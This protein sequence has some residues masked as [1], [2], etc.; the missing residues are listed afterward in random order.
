MLRVCFI[1]NIANY[2]RKLYDVTHNSNETILIT[3]LV[4]SKIS[5]FRDLHEIEKRFFL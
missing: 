3:Y 2:I 5:R 1:H 4:G